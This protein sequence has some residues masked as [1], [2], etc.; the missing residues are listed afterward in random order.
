LLAGALVGASALSLLLATAGGA[1]RATTAPERVYTVNVTMNDSRLVLVHPH[2]SGIGNQYIQQQGLWATFP[3]GAQIKFVFVNNGSKT[4]R[5]ALHVFTVSDYPYGRPQTF[6]K[7][8]KVVP[9]GGHGE[10]FAIFLYRG[11][12]S[13]QELLNSKPHGKAVPITIY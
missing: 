2:H 11:S 8:R 1:G 4:Y 12:Y 13:L 3:R 10:L 9:P 6:V 5:P 7:A